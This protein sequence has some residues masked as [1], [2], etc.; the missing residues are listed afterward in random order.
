MSGCRKPRTSWG[1]SM[2]VEDQISQATLRELL[3]LVEQARRL[4]QLRAQLLERLEAG[5]PVEPGILSARV[6]HRVR[7]RLTRS[8]LVALIGPDRVR[9]LVERVPPSQS[10]MLDVR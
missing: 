1:A 7:R 8:A 6:V 2:R 4:R 5:T 10:R 9:A 3:A